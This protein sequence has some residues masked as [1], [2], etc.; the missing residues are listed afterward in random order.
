M[1]DRSDAAWAMVKHARK[2]NRILMPGHVVRFTAQCRAVR[3]ALERDA[4]PVR[5]I[6]CYQHRTQDRY[7]TYCK[8]HLAMKLMIHQL[9]LCRWFADSPV[10]RVTAKERF[11]LG[12]DYPSSLWAALEFE[13]GGIATLQTGWLLTGSQPGFWEDGLEIITDKRRF[14]IAFN[15]G[16][17]TRGPEGVERPDVFYD[18]ALHMELDYW[19]SCVEHEREP[20]VVTPEDGAEAVALAERVITSAKGDRL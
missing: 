1:A 14:T 17:E 11:F 9:D 8:P 3:S 13:N 16:Y 10:S 4:S 12:D 7:T 2:A 6:R 19:A 20:E 18:P 15:E 5:A